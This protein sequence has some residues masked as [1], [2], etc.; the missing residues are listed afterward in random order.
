MKKQSRLSRGVRSKV[1]AMFICVI[2]IL[3]HQC[4]VMFEPSLRSFS[5]LCAPQM[6]TSAVSVPKTNKQK[7]RNVSC[8]CFVCQSVTEQVSW[9]S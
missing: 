1:S 5:R 6:G 3:R 4:D 7:K 9:D 2:V 8:V